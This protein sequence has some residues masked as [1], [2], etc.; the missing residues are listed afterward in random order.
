M[1]HESE[2]NLPSTVPSDEPE[3]LPPVRSPK[4]SVALVPA[5]DICAA[6]SVLRERVEE[7]LTISSDQWP[8]GRE[9]ELR[10]KFAVVPTE[11]M[12]V[13]KNTTPPEEE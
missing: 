4:V 9:V 10:L 12:A 6:V 11:I 8:D 7:V 5:P 3:I 1:D 13:V 2:K